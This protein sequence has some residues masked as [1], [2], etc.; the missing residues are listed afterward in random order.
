MKKTYFLSYDFHGSKVVKEF[1][2]IFEFATWFDT[3]LEDINIVNASIN[4]WTETK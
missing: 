2:Q 3:I 4:F 1:T